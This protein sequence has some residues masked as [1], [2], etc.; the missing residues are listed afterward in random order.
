[1][2]RRSK[3]ITSLLLNII[4]IIFAFLA[5]ISAIA[6]LLP[7]FFFNLGNTIIEITGNPDIALN[8]DRIS[9]DPV[10]YTITFGLFALGIKW[11]G[12]KFKGD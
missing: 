7:T 5:G 6:W 11:L 9:N 1:M 8:V 2:H 12:N 3:N 10:Y 4:S